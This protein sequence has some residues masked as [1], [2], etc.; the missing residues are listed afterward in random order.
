MYGVNNR[1]RGDTRVSRQILIKD[2]YVIMK[3]ASLPTHFSLFVTQV[4]IAAE[5]IEPPPGSDF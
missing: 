1:R 2:K 3:V 5:D 4:A